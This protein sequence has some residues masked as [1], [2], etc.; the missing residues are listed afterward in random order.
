MGTDM[1][2][3]LKL[4]Y[5]CRRDKCKAQID[6]QM[7]AQREIES[8]VEQMN[9][10]RSARLFELNFQLQ[11]LAKDKSEEEIKAIRAE[12]EAIYDAKDQ[13]RKR[14]ASENENII[15]GFQCEL[16]NCQDITL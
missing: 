16:N 7:K 3:I 8:K 10:V 5:D 11:H 4:F 1:M 2:D 13:E 6:K 14:L 9:Q 12:L 15:A